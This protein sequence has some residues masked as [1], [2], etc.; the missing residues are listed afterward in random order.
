[1]SAKKQLAYSL[2]FLILITSVIFINPANSAGP[3]VGAKCP[4][5]NFQM[6]S[7]GKTFTCK[8]IKGKL[9]W[10]K[11]S[12][13]PT[14]VFASETYPWQ[15]PCDP[16]PWVPAEWKEYEKF[17]LRYFRCSR[18]MRFQDVALPATKPQSELTPVSALNAV[19]VCKVPEVAV[20][21]D[22]GTYNNVGHRNTWKFTGDLNV[23]VIPVQ[24]NDFRATKTV[25]EEY[26][27]YFDY[28]KEMFF[29][30]SDGNTR[31]N[32]R[33]PENYLQINATLDSFDTGGFLEKNNRF[34]WKLLDTPKYQSA[35]FSV[36]DPVI[37]F[38]NVKLTI[39]V[40]PLS[41]PDNYIAHHP[42][43]RM[44][45]VV[46]NEGMI[47]A[48][49]I[50]PPANT[51]SADDWYGVDPYL[52]L[53]EIHH[54][55]GML[56]DH[57]GESEIGGTFYG[58]GRWGHMSGMLTDFILWDKWLTG[59]LDDSQVICAKSS[60]VGT[61]WIKPA[62]YFGK[63]EKFLVIPLSS[64]KLI[65][66]ESQRA[67]GVNFKLTKESQ[68]ALVYTIDVLDNRYD[69]GFEVLRPA[70]RKTDVNAGPFTLWDAPLKLNEEISV[71]GFK[72]KVIESGTFGDVIK[73]EK[74]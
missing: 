59:M 37:D 28:I 57:L 15:S 13:N 51:K 26:G 14:P 66:I 73:V 16:D 29:K 35:I 63:F 44:D 10:D 43:F 17:A 38:T 65:A 36:A 21:T 50:M 48:N 71:W 47:P 33:V 46:T 39:I 56:S 30:I 52:H 60:G 20:Q 19:S 32:M 64:T 68:G 67:A 55:T 34:K 27:K 5:V 49:Y 7:N 4:A 53:H 31:I 74:V 70:N 24:F 40:V 11:G 3:K 72:I 12:K 61:Y 69:G 1:M 23:Q 6:E 9:L 8:K 58:T 54:A 41:V 2:A 62:T 18:P 25:R 42:K 45:N 22:K